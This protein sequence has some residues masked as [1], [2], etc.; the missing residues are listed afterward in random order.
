MKGLYIVLHTSQVCAIVLLALEVFFLRKN[1]K[2]LLGTVEQLVMLA[3]EH[4][5]AIIETHNR[6]V[7][8]ENLVRSTSITL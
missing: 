8:T 7:A 6:S 4:Q 3:G 1:T 5:N 2:A